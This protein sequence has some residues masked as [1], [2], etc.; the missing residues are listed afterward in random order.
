MTVTSGKGCR[1]PNPCRCCVYYLTLLFSVG[2][3]G[4]TMCAQG[5]LAGFNNIVLCTLYA[6]VCNEVSGVQGTLK[7]QM[8][9]VL[10]TLVPTLQRLSQPP[11]HT[12]PHQQQEQSSAEITY[13]AVSEIN[14]SK[15]HTYNSDALNTCGMV[16]GRLLVTS[17]C[18]QP[19][20]IKL[21]SCCC[22]C[23]LSCNSEFAKEE[24]LTVLS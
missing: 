11:C 21:T 1:Q 13:Y 7:S 6:R 15:T 10:H 24:P 18:I 16:V 5:S 4:A 14:A 19:N 8:M 3:L 9:Y 2:P 22:F 20:N 23:Y 17:C 12:L